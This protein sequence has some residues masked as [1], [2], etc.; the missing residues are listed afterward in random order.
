MEII[1]DKDLTPHKL[2]QIVSLKMQHWKYSREKHINWIKNNI[3]GNDYH[4]L[5]FNNSES[6]IAY[7][8][9][10]NVTVN[11]DSDSKEYMG[12]GNVCVDKLYGD[13]G[14]GL[15]MMN[16]ATFMVK[17][18]NQPGIL[19]CKEDLNPFYQKAGWHLFSGN[20]FISNKSNLNSVF[21]TNEITMGEIFI[22]KNF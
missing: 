19:L 13:K 4:L 16:L 8:N 2:N 15:L 21:T 22:N 20:S 7:L 9:L 5:L 6:L 1:E 10:V 17:Q 3:S 18:L 14:Y 12:I 11:C